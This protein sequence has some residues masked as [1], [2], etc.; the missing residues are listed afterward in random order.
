MSTKL[1]IMI[2]MINDFDEMQRLAESSR[3]STSKYSNLVRN[4]Q[5]ETNKTIEQVI[6]GS[7]KAEDAAEQM[8]MYSKPLQ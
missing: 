5:Q 7:T 4:I 2:K 6:D 3:K 1:L 8:K